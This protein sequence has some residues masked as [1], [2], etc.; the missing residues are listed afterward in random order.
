MP[1]H[2]PPKCT[3]SSTDTDFI[4]SL[5]AT[6]SVDTSQQEEAATFWSKL[7][8][9]N[10]FCFVFPQGHPWTNHSL[11]WQRKKKRVHVSQWF[12]T[13]QSF[14]KGL[15]WCFPVEPL[16]VQP[17]PHSYTHMNTAGPTGVSH[18]SRD[19]DR[20]AEEAGLTSQPSFKIQ[21]TQRPLSK[22]CPDHPHQGGN[23]HSLLPGY[24]HPGLYHTGR[25]LFAWPAVSTFRPR[26]PKWKSFRA[27]RVL[28][29]HTS[30]SP[31]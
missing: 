25:H 14:L 12:P 18:A 6:V 21:P 20:W 10:L 15:H 9:L 11:K 4:D 27:H 28:C 24:L 1:P 3:I 2:S 26:A 19:K 29:T 30:A 23:D 16:P 17:P 5:W 22:A 7:S 8:F 31:G 13:M